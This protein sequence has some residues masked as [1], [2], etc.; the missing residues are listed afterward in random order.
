MRIYWFCPDKIFS[1][2]KKPTDNPSFRL[3]CFYTHQKLIEGGH[4]SKIVSSTKDI[5]DPDVVIF[6]SFGEEELELAKFVKSKG[7]YLV[8]DYS[9]NIRG[10]PV[11]EETKKLCDYLACCSTALA[12]IEAQTYGPKAIVIKDPYDDFPVIKNMNHK[13]NKLKVVWSG[14]SGNAPL[15]E[16]LL[17]PI[18]LDLGMEFVE[19]SNRPNSTILWDRQTWY[20]EMAKCDI[21]ICPQDQWSF[22]CKSNV[23][24]TTSMALG[25]PVIASPLLSYQE[26]IKN[27]ENGFIAHSLEDWRDYMIQLKSKELREYISYKAFETISEYSIDNIYKKWENVF[28]SLVS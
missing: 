28:K 12:G 7:K 5:V 13:N 16:N 18:V 24:V 27:G 21:C 19:I 4:F 22:P 2:F 8:H 20:L 23:K 6:M 17:K 14:M 15:V 9:E 11:L 3:R 10:I 1:A 26:T 25:V